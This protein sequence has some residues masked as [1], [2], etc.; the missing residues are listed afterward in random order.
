MGKVLNKYIGCLIVLFFSVSSYAQRSF[1]DYKKVSNWDKLSSMVTNCSSNVLPAEVIKQHNE[2]VKVD[3]PDIPSFPKTEDSEYAKRQ[4]KN[5]SPV[6]STFQIQKNKAVGD[7]SCVTSVTEQGAATVTVPILC[8]NEPQNFQPEVAMSY[9]SFMGNGALGYGWS[10][11]GVAVISRVSRS[12]YYDGYADGVSSTMSDAFTLNGQR[13]I[14]VGHSLG[15]YIKYQTAQGNIKVQAIL[16]NGAIKCFVVRYPN[17][18]KAEFN[19]NNGLSF[20]VDKITNRVGRTIYFFYEKRNNH[21]RIVSIKYGM[22]KEGTI[23]FHYMARTGVNKPVSYTNGVEIT[24]DYLLSDILTYFNK[25]LIRKYTL[26]YMERGLVDV[27][28]K[29]E[30]S[31]GS[32]SLNPLF[33]YYGKDNSVRAYTT[34]QTQLMSWYNFKD[35]PA[36]ISVNKGKFDYGNDNDGLLQFPNK[37]GY[38]QGHKNA[39]LFSHSKNWTENQFDGNEEIIISTGLNNNL[40]LGSCRIKTEKDF[41]DIFSV[42]IDKFDGDEI[43]KINDV[44]G[45]TV[46]TLKFTVYTSSVYAGIAKK[47][48]RKFVLSSLHNGNI[49][50][51]YFYSG[52]FDGNGSNEIL[53]V[54]ADKYLGDATGTKVYL[55]DLENNKILYKGSPFSYSANMIGGNRSAQE[56]YNTSDKLYA[57]DYNNDGKTE[58]V[59]IKDDGVYFYSFL[60]SN[61]YWTCCFKGNDSCLT[62]EVVKDSRLIVGDYNGDGKFDFLLSPLKGSSTTW[63]LYAG[64]GNTSF[65]HKTISLT[66]YNDD[67]TEFYA[68]D[69]NQ[70]GQT[71]LVKKNKGILTIYYVAD[72]KNVGNFN[73]PV[74]EKSIVLPTNI[75]SRNNWYSMLVVHKD[76]KVDKLRVNCSDAEKRLLTGA[77]NS[78][79]IITQYDYAFLN[80]E[81]GQTYSS[82]YINKEPFRLYKGAM[83]VVAECKNLYEGKSLDDVFYQ[84]RNAVI[85]KQG[86][87]F[88]GF[89]SV[90]S[91][92]NV[93]GEWCSK[94]FDPFK[95]GCLLSKETAKEKY[96]YTYDVKTK[97]NK[98]TNVNLSR[99]EYANNATQV[100]TTTAYSYSTYGNML[101]ANVNYG[102]NITSELRRS[103]LNV[104][105]DEEYV[106]GLIDSEEKVVSR[107]GTSWKTVI[108]NTYD[109]RHFLQSTAT[110]INGNLSS[111]ENYGY[112][113]DNLV[114]Y[115][116]LY[117]YSSK[118]ATSNKFTYNQ[119]GQV[120]T[121]TNGMGFKESMGYNNI[122]LLAS[123]EDHLGNKEITSYDDWG[124]IVSVVHTDKTTTETQ[125]KWSNGE[126]GSLFLVTTHETGKPERSVFYDLKGNIVRTSELRFDGKYLSVDK[127][128]DSRNRVSK[129][130]YPFKTAPNKWMT[131]SYDQYNRLLNV[132]YASG[133]IDAYSY[134]G[135]STTITSNGIRTVKTLNPI[136]DLV[137]VTD[138]SGTTSFE[139]NGN[140]QPTK[141]TLP[142]NIVTTIGY[143]TFGRRIKISDPNAGVSTTSYDENGNVSRST[144]ARNREITY[145]YDVYDRIRSRRVEGMGD[146][147]YTYD[148][149]GNLAS[150]SMSNGIGA[151]Y[152]Y[153]G[154]KRLVGIKQMGLDG[155][156]FDK[157]ISYEDGNICTIAYSSNLGTLAKENYAYSNGTLTGI[158]LAN[159]KEIYRLQEE[160]EQGRTIKKHFGNISSVTSYDV[161]GHVV[162]QKALVDN[163]AI[164]DFSYGYDNKTE[165]LISRADNK[166]RLSENFEYDE[167]NRLIRFG[168]E[169][170][171]YDE[172]GNVIYNS[173][174][175]EFS[176]GYSKPFAISKIENTR[177]LVSSKEQ[178]IGYNALG[179]INAIYEGKDV[180]V[181]NYDTE[182]NRVLLDYS[183]ENAEKSFKKY[184]FDNT[185]EIKT[186]KNTN[187]E[188]LYLGGDCYNAPAVLVRN[189]QGDWNLWYILRDNLGSITTI[190]DE[191][192]YVL[193][194]QRYD[195]WGNLRDVSTWKIF[196]H[197][198]DIP[199]LLLDRGYTG[200][201][202]MLP[203]GV[204]NMNARLYS[205]LLGR[206]LSPDPLVQFGDYSQNFNRYAYCLNNPFGGVDISG[207]SIAL[208]IGIAALVGAVGNVTA[209]AI[210]GQIHSFGD[211]CAA[212]G[213]GAVAGGLASVAVLGMGIASVGVISGMAAGAVAGFVGGVVTG[214][215]NNAFFDDDFSFKDIAIGTVTAC[216]LG[217]VSGG[218]A[219]K[220]QGRN[221]WTGELKNATISPQIGNLPENQVEEMQCPYTQEG[222]NNTTLDVETPQNNTES[223][224]TSG[225]AST[226]KTVYDL[227]E[228]PELQARYTPE[229]KSIMMKTPEIAGYADR[230][231]PGKYLGYGKDDLFHN[232]PGYFDKKIVDHGLVWNMQPNGHQTFALPGRINNVHGWFTIGIDQKGIIYH[233]CFML[234][235]NFQKIY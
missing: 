154:C 117:K 124:N 81:F 205:P 56:A 2:I 121:R 167:L 119:Y 57:M 201:E 185:Y 138:A 231:A 74:E 232:F 220:I 206:F 197:T 158:A 218:I 44:A 45:N 194:E 173:L 221:I 73:I 11:S 75:L 60:N 159:G 59:M 144:D 163:N 169:K 40:S 84:Y 102:A 36:Q 52:D 105:N 9:N 86:L 70:D 116:T 188:I 15:N 162:R 85:H 115:K 107:N 68:Q 178:F 66:N 63:N 189:N 91:R 122:G 191:N 149:N 69:M 164:Q 58:I 135:L 43:I 230:V 112:N 80:D 48:T 55:I 104:D 101:S 190:T 54:T 202:H 214:I 29:I 125:K 99:K 114:N 111:Q 19:T 30:C 131:Y 217:G 12:I 136:G 156:W 76:G 133:K 64:I 77:V 71:D 37:I 50:P 193:S 223:N 222:N 177:N 155:Y 96:V 187:K 182:G 89:E 18:D 160:D 67:D 137:E 227:Y 175:G 46:D 181:F 38:Y 199:E 235:K 211:F 120:E 28:S 161:E 110:Y 196:E 204:I 172:S 53:V 151:E 118:K 83:Y 147:S 39:G 195:A 184:Y 129:V 139:Y 17:G 26:S 192:G 186:S 42:D 78:L 1:L 166:Y 198:E 228:G 49:M 106:L 32:S 113:A 109:N 47:Y 148:K 128:Y 213:V 23:E 212:A 103:Y 90:N 140:G 61:N 14:E 225:G 6:P 143:D 3:E 7:I 13:L 97:S 152:R 219:A 62:N 170:A 95:F 176:Y 65:A 183:D 21:Y 146:Q 179:R 132:D 215:G 130:S 35:N 229:G 108:K 92:N 157:E 20:Y 98:I 27:I 51:K 24:Y 153:D 126:A 209:K 142:N 208:I 174:V 93:T 100:N 165:N 123:V 79:G 127:Q 10:L 226:E 200:H 88:C 180:A 22:Q 207:K 145:T 233:R 5:T 141:V 72:F 150:T 8:Y 224:F 16:E 41:V 25:S 203:F 216:V 234:N 34:Q 168:D 171:E 87:G 31:N 33:F 94:V 134:S 210:N 82:G 4:Y